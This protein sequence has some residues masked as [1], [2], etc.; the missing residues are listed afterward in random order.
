[1]HAVQKLLEEIR[2][3]LR[4]ISIAHRIERDQIH[5]PRIEA[6]LN[7]QSALDA[8]SQIAREQQQRER[9]SHLAK[10]Q[11]IAQAHAAVLA[12]L[13]ITAFLQRGKQ[14]GARGLQG[15]HQAESH[16]GDQGQAAGEEQRPPV[17]VQIIADRHRQRQPQLRKQ[18]HAPDA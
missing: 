14:A 7:P 1:M 11:R 5:V 12:K 18:M 13:D 16:A 9:G 4:G 17:G 3:A 10:H 6:L 8:E 15:R 2:R